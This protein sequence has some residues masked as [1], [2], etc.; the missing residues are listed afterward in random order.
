M[1]NQGKEVDEMFCH[2]QSYQ[3]EDQSKIFDDDIEEGRIKMKVKS[4]VKA[5]LANI[6]DQTG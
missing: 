3:N 2:P 4:N 5:G 1:G 6:Q